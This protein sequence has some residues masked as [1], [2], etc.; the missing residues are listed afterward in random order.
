MLRGH[1]QR[2]LSGREVVRQKDDQLRRIVHRQQV[3][4]QFSDI[5]F[6]VG[7]REAHRG[8]PAANFQQT[9]R[10]DE[11][12]AGGCRTVRS[13]VAASSTPMMYI[14]SR[15]SPRM[16]TDVWAMASRNILS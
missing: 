15:F 8:V 14:A 6:R 7:Q 16:F 12:A 4:R 5:A 2:I 1:R 11:V 10:H 9:A 13:C 3:R